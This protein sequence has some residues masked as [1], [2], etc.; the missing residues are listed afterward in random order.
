MTYYSKPTDEEC[1]KLMKMIRS[2][3][4][5]SQFADP[6]EYAQ[7]CYENETR[8]NIWYP[9]LFH[10]MTQMSDEEALAKAKEMGKPILL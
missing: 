9:G 5:Y 8:F 3:E 4:F 2:G 10:Y 6:D 1:L 7:A